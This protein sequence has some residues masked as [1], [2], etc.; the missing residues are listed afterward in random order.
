MVLKMYRTCLL[1]V[2]CMPNALGNHLQPP[3]QQITIDT[4]FATIK[5]AIQFH[6]TWVFN[7]MPAM[8]S[9]SGHLHATS[10]LPCLR[11]TFRNT[12]PQSRERAS[13]TACRHRLRSVRTYTTTFVHSALFAES[14]PL[15][16]I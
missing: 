1:Y 8:I 4:M 2:A 7:P 12:S 16:L 15:I 13:L 10:A 3:Y 9:H 14:W 11:I 6:S 5:A